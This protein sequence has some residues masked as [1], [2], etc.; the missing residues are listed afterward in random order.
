MRKSFGILTTLALLTLGA[1]SAG[2]TPATGTSDTIVTSDGQLKLT[3]SDAPAQPG[4]FFI[5]G[6]VAGGPAMVTI[7]S[8]RYGSLCSTAITGH[9]T[10]G[11]G[12]VTLQ[13]TYSERTAICTADIRAITYRGEITGLAPGLYDVNVIHTNADGSSGT[14]LT[15]RVT[16]T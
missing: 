2:V 3:V 10:V 8:T 5:A 15:Q 1:C 16:V 6:S 9:A 13:V 4:V 14:V 12:V 7:A 11:P